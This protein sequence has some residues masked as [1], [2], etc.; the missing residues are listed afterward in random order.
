VQTSQSEI[1]INSETD[2]SC[3]EINPSGSEISI[4]TI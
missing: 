4:S 1:Y 2:I 3:S